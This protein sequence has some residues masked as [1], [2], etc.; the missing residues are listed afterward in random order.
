[1]SHCPNIIV[2]TVHPHLDMVRNVA[3]GLQGDGLAG[4]GGGVLVDACYRYCR[5]CRYCRYDQLPDPEVR[6]RA[7]E[8]G[9]PLYQVLK[10]GCL[11]G[12]LRVV[13]GSLDTRGAHFF[14]AKL[15]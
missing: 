8:L 10:A 9:E 11:Q 7:A 12:D 1:M 14:D 5:Y 13:A 4:G 3:A 2:S 6:V 15:T